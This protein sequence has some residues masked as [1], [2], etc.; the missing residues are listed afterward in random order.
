MRE[1]EEEGGNLPDRS[2]KAV[3]RRD[4]Q[5]ARKSDVNEARTSQK[6]RRWGA[7]HRDFAGFIPL[8]ACTRYSVRSIDLVVVSPWCSVVYVVLICHCSSTVSYESLHPH[9]NALYPR[10]PVQI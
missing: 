10:L 4:K 6:T 7:L 2:M 3:Y 9:G 8:L 5:E 1:E